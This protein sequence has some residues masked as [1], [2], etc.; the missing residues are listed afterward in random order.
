MQRYYLHIWVHA[1]LIFSYQ[2]EFIT[3]LIEEINAKL[4]E[5]MDMLL[6]VC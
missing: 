6:S 1:E 3:G 5:D 2:V 4:E